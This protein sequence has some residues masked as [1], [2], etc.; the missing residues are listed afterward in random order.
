MSSIRRT[1]AQ[2]TRSPNISSHSR[3]LRS[4]NVA[5]S[6]GTSSAARS[7]RLRIE[8]QHGV[9]RE[10]R[11]VGP[12]AQE[13]RHAGEALRPLVEA[14][15]FAGRSLV[16]STGQSGMNEARVELFEAR[17]MDTEA[18]RHRGPEILDQHMGA[19]DH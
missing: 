2:G 16:A 15:L 19:L 3:A 6:S 10:L 7:A 18:S 17:I 5:R 1:A 14:T 9:E 13:P 8:T 12:E 4:A 11:L